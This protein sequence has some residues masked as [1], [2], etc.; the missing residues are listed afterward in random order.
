M[1]VNR[2]QVII[3]GAAG[4]DFHN[5]NVYFRRNPFYEVV[6]FTAAQIPGIAGRRYPA[7]LAGKLYPKGVPIF[8]EEKLEALIRRFGV[9]QVV[10]AYSDLPYREVMKKSAIVESAGADFRLLGPKSTMLRSRRKV[11][12]VCAVRTGC[13]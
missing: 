4:R 3:A 9:E 13:G 2:R 7:R 10:L 1:N 8:P 5:F 12:A 6:A 11:I